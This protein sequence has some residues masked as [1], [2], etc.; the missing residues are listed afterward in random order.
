[1][2]AGTPLPAEELGELGLAQR[3]V[4]VLRQAA[5]RLDDEV[6]GEPRHHQPEHA[7]VGVDQRAAAVARLHRGGEAEEAAVVVDTGQRADV[8]AGQVQRGAGDAVVG[9]AGGMHPLPE[10][11]RAGGQRQPGR[12]AAGA[13][14]GRR[15]GPDRATSVSSVPSA[16][17][18]RCRRRPR[19]GRS[20]ASRADVEAGAGARPASLAA[21]RRARRRRPAPARRPLARPVQEA[22]RS[23]RP[24]CQPAAAGRSQGSG[25]PGRMLAAASVSAA[26]PRGAPRRRTVAQRAGASERV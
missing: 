11:R 25:G 3:I 23:R 5:G 8:A 15:R 2:A 20:P 6:L 14:A 18:T 19:A 9:E 17:V 24:A 10:P 12:G 22:P 26:R 21:R 13:V 7:A 4:D 16:S 1:M